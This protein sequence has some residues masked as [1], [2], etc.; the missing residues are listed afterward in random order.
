ML[1]DLRRRKLTVRFNL[2]DTD[3][4]G[5]IDEQDC[6]RA[7]ERVCQT[8]NVPPGSAQAERL[9]SGYV[10]LW[11]NLKGSSD[12]D[13]NQRVTLEEFLTSQE[14]MLSREGGYDGVI[15]SI[16]QSLLDTSDKDGDGQLSHEEFRTLLQSYGLSAEQATDMI[17]R[18]DRDD[19]G[20]LSRAE[21]LQA[22][23]EFHTSE[24]PEAPGNWLLGPF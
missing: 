11:Q 6:M 14:A 24:D 16:A 2:I 7:A 15:E 18:I 9:R 10:N 13:G 8:F 4:N 12:A 3:R 1:S 21:I 19:S 20:H 22:V 5:Y 23:R 17:R